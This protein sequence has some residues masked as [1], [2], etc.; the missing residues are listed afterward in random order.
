[1]E[2]K[3]VRNNKWYANMKPEQRLNR[4]ENRRIQNRTTDQ[5]QS[6]NEHQRKVRRI[7]RNALGNK[8]IAMEN[9]QCTPEP[10][11]ETQHV[12]GF[13]PHGSLGSPEITG[14]PFYP[15]IASEQV[16]DDKNDSGMNGS[17][18]SRRRYVTH[19]ERPALLQRRNQEFESSIGRGASTITDKDSCMAEEELDALQPTNPSMV[20][21]TETIAPTPT[22]ETTNEVRRP[23]VVEG[24]DD[25]VIFEEDN[26]E[27]EGYLFAGQGGA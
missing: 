21:N 26:E 1:M 3:K 2:A 15:S 27:Q 19:G 16:V 18:M 17:Q 12:N 7:K 14:T 11:W 13:V 20:I 5:N 22:P 9:P 8:S 24:N 6:R 4:R 10:V 25:G 23:V